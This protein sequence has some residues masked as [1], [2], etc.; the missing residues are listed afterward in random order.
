MS[1][2]RSAA[3]LIEQ[4]ER[5]QPRCES[6]GAMTMPVARSGMIWLECSANVRPT[7]RLRRLLALDGLTGHTRLPIMTEPAAQHVA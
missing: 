1:D 4:S 7:S 3:E 2:Q 5:D 6:C